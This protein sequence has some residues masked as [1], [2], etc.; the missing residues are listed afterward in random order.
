MAHS[1]LHILYHP[2]S[3]CFHYNPSCE[4]KDILRFLKRFKLK[5][6]NKFVD[7]NYRI[8]NKTAKLAL[9][10]K[11][12]LL[13]TNR[14]Q[15]NI[16]E[17]IKNGFFSIDSLDD[18]KQVLKQFPDDPTLHRSFSD[19]LVENNLP[20]VAA[21]SYNKAADLFLRSG[22]P[23]QA[24]V[25]T[26]LQW[27]IYAPSYREA[28]LF[29]SALREGIY[30][31]SSFKA[32]LKRLSNPEILA[33]MKNAV[34]VRFPSGHIEKKVGDTENDLYFVV[35]GQLKKTSF[36]PLKQKGMTTYE[37]LNFELSG[38]D[39]FGDIYP[40]D[41]KKVSE[42]YVETITD[43]ELI[44]IP[45]KAL[46]QIGRKYSNVES[47]IEALYM[48]RSGSEKSEF[49]PK[50]RRGERHQIVIKMTLEIYPE[51]SVNSPIILDGY[52]RDISI[53]GTCI[54]LDTK[55]VHV[56]DSIDSFHKKIKTAPIKMSFPS[57]GLEIKVPGQIVW[58]QKV[59]FRGGRTLALGVQ[60][61]N[62]SPKL[63]GLLFVFAD[64]SGI[65]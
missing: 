11:G 25:A 63:R 59:S 26:I 52:S 45:K 1:Q 24:M 50:N 55:D 62:L 10:K 23:L 36:S 64:N 39:F 56:L 29:F 44:K 3:L 60:F 42:S 40:L 48:E 49:P 8:S 54:V 6:Y 17:D 22:Q 65:Q 30:E 34:V 57:E 32:F 33:V 12:T 2:V 46:S 5:I 7:K 20:N 41:Q 37:K 53:G 21:S 19:M 9:R 14:Y 38:D 27:E 61:Q 35:S 13:G 58:T 15:I 18:F 47:V 4:P 43:V 28:Q 16:A 31:D 51:S